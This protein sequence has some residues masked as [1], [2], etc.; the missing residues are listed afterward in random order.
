MR[1]SVGNRVDSKTTARTGV[2]DRPAVSFLNER[3][4][5]KSQSDM[6]PPTRAYSSWRLLRVF[7]IVLG[8]SVNRPRKAIDFLSPPHREAARAPHRRLP[9]LEGARRI[10]KELRARAARSDG[11]EALG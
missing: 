1:C 11:E 5:W 7:C 4:V 6:T 8:T 10:S 2:L 3:L 9:P